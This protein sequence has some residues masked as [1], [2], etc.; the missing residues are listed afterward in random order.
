MTYYGKGQN[1]GSEYRG[2]YRGAGG[3]T[4]I[5]SPAG[6]LDYPVDRRL[7]Q[8]LSRRPYKG[9]LD[10]IIA[11][12]ETFI[13][14]ALT[15]VT[16]PIT[17]IITTAEAII[18]DP[19]AAITTVLEPT[20]TIAPTTVIGEPVSV[21]TADEPLFA[22]ND[23]AKK[24]TGIFGAIPFPILLM[25]AIYFFSRGSKISGSALIIAALF[26]LPGLLGNK[27]PSDTK[28]WLPFL[29]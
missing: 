22:A 25:A 19:L 6:G 7:I 28:G 2:L 13:E 23:V 5:V 15:T 18:S 21:I 29:M 17:E 26:F 27:K 16:E 11:A 14:S 9:F 1:R 20:P 10:D 8:Q 3:P 12:G 4:R 24:E